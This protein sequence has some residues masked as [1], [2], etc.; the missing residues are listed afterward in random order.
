ME[1]DYQK[2]TSESLQLIYDEGQK[3]LD[4]ITKSFREV[5]SKSY[6]VIGIL[7]SFLGVLI[8]E[9][10]TKHQIISLHGL[11]FFCLAFPTV[12]IFQN[13]LPVE[14]TFP[15]AIP[16]AMKQDYFEISKDFQ[17]EKY[18]AQR[19]RDC[20]IAILHNSNL[21]TK[22]AKRLK[23]GMRLILISLITAFAFWL[24]LGFVA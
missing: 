13:L 3:Q 20:E 15:G 18:L 10:I 7:F 11:L 24:W 1:I 5:N 22:R 8:T 21:L 16:S 6:I 2:Y 17:Y 19:I 14:Y 23:S 4:E 9:M 12:L